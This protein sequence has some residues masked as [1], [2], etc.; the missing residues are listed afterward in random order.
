MNAKI[1][2]VVRGVGACLPERVVTN[3]E[4]AAKVDTSDEWI[5]QRTGI[6]QRY[7]AGDHET[8]STLGTK[9]ALR[10]LD[11]AGMA[12]ADIDLVIVATSTPDY[13]FPATATQIQ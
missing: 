9:A 3:D 7:V 5:A 1:R 12:P 10:A 13:T 8:T 4:L 11:R 6:R 2:S